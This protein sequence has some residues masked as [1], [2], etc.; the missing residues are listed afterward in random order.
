MKK[1]LFLLVTALVLVSCEK[2]GILPADLRIANNSNNGINIV[3]EGP[4]NINFMLAPN[5]DIIFELTPGKY[6]VKFYSHFF[7]PYKLVEEHSLKIYED[8]FNWIIY[9]QN[10]K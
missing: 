4:T 8:S 9:S 10:F 6:K 2:Y 5:R 3:I 7:S 1:L